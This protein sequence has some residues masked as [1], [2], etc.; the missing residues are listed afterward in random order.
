MRCCV[1][2]LTDHPAQ[3]CRRGPLPRLG[4]VPRWRGLRACLPPA[5]VGEARCTHTRVRHKHSACAARQVGAR[6]F[7][8]A[9]FSPYRIAD[10][11]VAALERALHSDGMQAAAQAVAAA[12]E[13]HHASAD[14]AE[15]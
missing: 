8:G 5:C 3:L 14:W 2:H 15:P 9:A 10:A 6:E 4:S 11:E 13:E 1:L 12:R 7:P